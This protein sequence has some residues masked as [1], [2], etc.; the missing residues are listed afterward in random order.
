M[1]WTK[2]HYQEKDYWSLIQS[3]RRQPNYTHGALFSEMPKKSKKYR[4]FSL[5]EGYL[6]LSKMP[7][8]GL[9]DLEK[10]IRLV[11][12]IVY[13]RDGRLWL[14]INRDY[15]RLQLKRAHAISSSAY[16]EAG[17]R[18]FER[19]YFKAINNLTR[20]LKAMSRYAF[21]FPQT[22]ASY[23][24]RLKRIVFRF[25]TSV[26]RLPSSVANQ[27]ISRFLVLF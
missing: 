27:K 10:P 15:V 25:L 24:R 22:K 18:K 26:L 5:P 8:E 2:L 14:Q 11:P 20:E 7:L 1:L 6:V 13:R 4:V 12:F 3:L 9:Q 16:W 19:D 17:H 23:N 21:V